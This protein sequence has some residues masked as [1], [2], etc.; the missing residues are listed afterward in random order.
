M[1]LR[2][3]KS[4]I[5]KLEEEAFVH[6]AN[7]LDNEFYDKVVE[8][9]KQI[10]V[11]APRTMNSED[12]SWLSNAYYRLISLLDEQGYPHDTPFILPLPE[13]KLPETLQP[14]EHLAENKP[15]NQVADWKIPN[16]DEKFDE[17]KYLDHIKN[18]T[19][20]IVQCIERALSK[21]Q[22]SS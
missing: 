17:E 18:H 3:L 6:G 5:I 9:L 16:T 19:S 21:N 14:L 20:E 10:Y 2:E 15:L 7:K 22:P 12:Y 1:D 8:S 13:Y 4:E 11:E